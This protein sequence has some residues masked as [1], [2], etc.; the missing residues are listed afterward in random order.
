MET[1]DKKCERK[2]EEERIIYFLLSSEQ[3]RPS[4]A[5]VP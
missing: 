5:I 3:Q 2:N 4:V 1:G